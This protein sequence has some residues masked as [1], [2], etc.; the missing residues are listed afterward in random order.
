MTISR[1]LAVLA[2]TSHADVFTPDG[3]AAYVTVVNRWADLVTVIVSG[4][5]EEKVYTFAELD[6][7]RDL[8][9]IQ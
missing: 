8:L 5:S 4:T 6:A 2:R 9:A 7:S 1:A 3:D